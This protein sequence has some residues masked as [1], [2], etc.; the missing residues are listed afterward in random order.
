[1]NKSEF[2]D[3]IR[4]TRQELDAVLS[5][6]DKQQ[7]LRPRT[8]G[9]WSVKDV[10]AHIAW[11][12]REMVGVLEAHAL[13]GS[14]LWELP[15]EPRNAAIHAVNQD[16]PLEDVLVEARLVTQDLLR[17]LPALTEAD[18]TDATRFPGM[19]PDWIPR[20]V[21]AS[22]TCEHYPEHAAEIRRAFGI[23]E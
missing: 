6:L 2:V 21:I 10:I 7:M 14:E 22:N 4:T 23:Q 9:D 15:L 11:Y 8:C 20:E 12:E 18:L 17:L 3:M 16:R 1:M 19:P 5:Q 13:A